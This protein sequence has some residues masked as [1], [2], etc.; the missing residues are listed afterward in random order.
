VVYVDSN[1][2]PAREAT[3]VAD[4]WA[5]TPGVNVR[6]R[7]YNLTDGVEVGRNSAFI[8]STTATTVTIDVT[9]TKG[10]K[11]YVLQV[12]SETDAS[13]LYCQSSGLY[14]PGLYIP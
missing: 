9:L 4:I 11:A 12:T 3:V 1:W 14:A 2:F 6:L 8:T 10:V 5:G 7:L 13:D